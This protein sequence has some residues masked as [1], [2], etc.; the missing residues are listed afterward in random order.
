MS[1]LRSQAQQFTSGPMES[2]IEHAT[3]LSLELDNTRSTLLQVLDS[4]QGPDPFQG[5][6]PKGNSASDHGQIGNQPNGLLARL[7]FANDRQKQ[8]HTE[9]EVIVKQLRGLVS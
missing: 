1:D 8:I 3:Q 6:D 4:L 9:I 5:P 7:Q 2:L